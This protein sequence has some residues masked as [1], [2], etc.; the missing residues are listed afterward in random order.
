MTVLVTMVMSFRMPKIY[1]STTT[2]LPSL[3]SGEGGGMLGNLLMG[4]GGGGGGGGGSGSGGLNAA[5]SS[6]GIAMPGAP[7]TPTDIFTAML[8]SRIMADEVIRQFDLQS[9]WA[10]RTMVAARVDLERSTKIT[11]L[12][13][14]TIKIVVEASNPQL[15]ADIANFY[16]TNLDRLNRTVNVT[17]AGQT[18]AF[19]ERRLVETKAKLV[20][21]EAELKEFQ[22]K[23]KTVAVEQQVFVLVQAAAMTQAQIR[24]LELQS[25]VM[26]TYLSQDNPEMARVQSSLD[27]LRK[28][29][30]AM[31]SGKGG[32]GL[33][34]GDRQHTAMT[35]VPTLA[36]DY[37]R[38]LRDLKLQ[39][40]L[41]ALLTSQYEQAKLAEARDTPTVQVLDPAVPA[42]EKSR[43]IIRNNMM[44]AGAVSL[45][46]GIALAFLLEYVRQVMANRKNSDV[47]L[48]SQ[49]SSEVGNGKF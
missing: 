14:K 17:K 42:E 43:P 1:E 21:K 45:L 49:T 11:V 23:N 8:K 2:L 7:A 48:T 18:R 34:P 38:A 47:P 10:K 36:L 27:E 31:E 4:S 20:Q 12:K 24:A 3:G 39:E 29:L 19:L 44:F 28:Q 25:E 22:V 13:D 15:A 37:G 26:G 40:T 9:V 35:T 30:Y 41:Y 16:V 33:V 5:V 6:L 32:K 46:L